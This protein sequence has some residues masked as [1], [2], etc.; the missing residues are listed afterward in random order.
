[1]RAPGMRLGAAT[2]M[3]LAF[4]VTACQN[5][6]STSDHLRPHTMEVLEGGTVVLTAEAATQAGQPSVVAGALSVRAGQQTAPLTVRFVTR[7]GSVITPP[8]DYWLRVTPNNPGVATWQ[9]ASEAEFGGRLA[10]HAPGTVLLTFDWMH[11]A[12]GRGH[13]DETFVISTT[14]QP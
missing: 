6:V 2:A 7:G 8:S 13:E 12:V 1:M 3:V 4:V 5:P 10:G 14:V 11:G 9:R